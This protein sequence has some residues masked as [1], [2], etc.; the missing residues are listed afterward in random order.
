MISIDCVVYV[1][2]Y[3]KS[4]AFG[5]PLTVDVVTAADVQRLRSEL[6]YML[7]TD[8][9]KSWDEEKEFIRRMVFED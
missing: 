7:L 8:K 1:C 5:T 3:I 9:E 4:I 6:A 2:K